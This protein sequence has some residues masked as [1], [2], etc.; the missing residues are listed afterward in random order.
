MD[1][2]FTDVIGIS[3][4]YKPT[5]AALNIPDWYK[6][7]ESYA[8][9]E[10]KPRGDGTPPSTI[11][12]CMPV[13]DA[14]TSGYIIYS[15]VDVF[16]TKKD[17]LVDDQPANAHWFEWPSLEPISFHDMIQAPTH[18]N[19]NSH[20]EYPKWISP[21]GIKTPPGY[22]CLFIQPTHRESVFTILPGIVDTDSYTAPVNFPFT[23]NDVEFEGLIPAGTPIAQVI[24]FKRESWSMG[25]GGKDEL[26]ENEK[27]IKRLKTK[28]FDAYKTQH[29][30]IKDYK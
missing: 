14:I 26:L 21:W 20:I 30:V 5:P 1:I 13:F 6:A 16:V 25:F 8:N 27:I 28:F 7:M 2:I 11:K 22:S 23:L 18:P 29:R 17:G 3:D 4:E 10:K 12:R 19:R 15:Y 9:G 24:P